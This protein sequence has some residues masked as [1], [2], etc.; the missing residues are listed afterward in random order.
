MLAVTAF[1]EDEPLPVAADRGTGF[2]GAAPSKS[3]QGAPV[4]RDSV[5]IHTDGHVHATGMA[6]AFPTD[7]ASSGEMRGAERDGGAAKPTTTLLPGAGAVEAPASYAAAIAASGEGDRFGG[8]AFAATRDDQPSLAEILSTD[9]EAARRLGFRSGKPARRKRT[10]S[11]TD[12]YLLAL[13][14]Q[15]LPATAAITEEGEGA[16][17]PRVATVVSTNFKRL[18]LRKKGSGHRIGARA[19]YSKGYKKKNHR[20]FVGKNFCYSCGTEVRAR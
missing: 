16:A 9:P 19:K 20:N 2:K 18:N 6:T 12:P 14:G 8:T 3:R 1:A 5:G 15:Q 7:A 13:T 10:S 11:A 4:E 17:G